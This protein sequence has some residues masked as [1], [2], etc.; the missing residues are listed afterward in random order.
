MDVENKCWRR[1]ASREVDVWTF[2]PEHNT[3]NF[4]GRVNQVTLGQTTHRQRLCTKTNRL[5]AGHEWT[6]GLKPDNRHLLTN[7]VIALRVRARP[8]WYFGETCTQ[9]HDHTATSLPAAVAND[10]A[11]SAHGKN[12]FFFCPLDRLTR[13]SS[14]RCSPSRSQLAG[15]GWW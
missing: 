11:S 10:N 1:S 14:H 4:S 5:P 3:A 13:F 15:F 2:F 8:S 7:W 12:L 6:Q 9:E